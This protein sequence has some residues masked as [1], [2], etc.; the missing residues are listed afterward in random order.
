MANFFT[1]AP[2]PGAR[3]KSARGSSALAARLF[4]PRFE[5]TAMRRAE[6]TQ[7]CLRSAL[8]RRRRSLGLTQEQAAKVLGVRRLTYHRIEAGGRRIRF[9]DIAALC[10]LYQCHPAELLE[11]S[12][13]AA[14]Y[15]RA[16][17]TLLAV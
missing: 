9:A 14:A 12:A 16:A 15:T 5:E 1:N 7:A 17:P 3:S 2:P 8:R 13:L 11:D 4:R 6:D 10:E